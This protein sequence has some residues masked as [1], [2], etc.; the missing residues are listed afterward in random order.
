MHL[1]LDGAQDVVPGLQPAA[2]GAHGRVV[3]HCAQ[4]GKHG[5]G[6]VGDVLGQVLAPLLLLARRR[7]LADLHLELQPASARIIT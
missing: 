4:H 7:R 6:G 1:A 3:G 5:G 2:L